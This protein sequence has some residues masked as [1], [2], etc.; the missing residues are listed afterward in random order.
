MV[1]VDKQLNLCS[2]DWMRSMMVCYN[3]FEKKTSPVP[4]MQARKTGKASFF[5]AR[6]SVGQLSVL[7]REFQQRFTMHCLA[8]V[9]TVEFHAGS[10][11]SMSIEGGWYHWL[12]TVQ[13]TVIQ[14]CI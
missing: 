10:R 13:P 6:F 14:G 9:E 11:L 4:L 3:A 5:I 12:S 7:S 8:S 2:I 1:D